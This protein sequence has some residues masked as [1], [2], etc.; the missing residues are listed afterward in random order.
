MHI[1]VKGLDRTRNNAIR[2]L[3]TRRVT[4][5]LLRASNRSRSLHVWI[6]D[7]NGPR[8]GKDHV[9]QFL[10]HL[11]PTGQIVVRHRDYGPYTGL[12]I[13]VMRTIRAVKRAIGRRRSNRIDSFRRNRFDP[14]FEK[15]ASWSATHTRLVNEP[16]TNT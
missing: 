12:P 2:E 8:G 3:I 4:A 14:D 15:Q 11:R 6:R 16:S 7:I 9:I 5:K 1:S 13:A 10:V